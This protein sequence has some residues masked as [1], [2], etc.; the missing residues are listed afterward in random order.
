[1]EFFRNFLDCT[2]PSPHDGASVM[3]TSVMAD[4]IPITKLLA[5]LTWAEKYA[6]LLRCEELELGSSPSSKQLDSVGR[7]AFLTLQ[8][9]TSPSTRT[10]RRILRDERRIV[11]YVDSKGYSRRKAWCSR[12]NALDEQMHQ[13]VL[14]MWHRGVF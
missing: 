12:S 2:K 10:L 3:C 1:M 13:W 7:W 14:R 11:S 5:R 6:I 4:Q 8:L 9:K